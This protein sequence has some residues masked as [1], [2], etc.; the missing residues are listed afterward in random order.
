[1][2]KW[3][4]SFCPTPGNCSPPTPRWWMCFSG[5]TGFRCGKGCRQ[6]NSSNHQSRQSSI[7][8]ALEKAMGGWTK[9]HQWHKTK[10]IS[11]YHE[12]IKAGSFISKV[13]VTNAKPGRDLREPDLET[14]SLTHNSENSLPPKTKQ[15]QNPCLIIY[16]PYSWNL[17][18]IRHR[19]SELQNFIRIADSTWYILPDQ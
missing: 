18:P 19:C 16:Y 17:L 13:R 6:L 10:V 7:W 14:N 9:T 8:S 11:Q 1:M 15:N 12:C 3:C 5:C 2:I 4:L